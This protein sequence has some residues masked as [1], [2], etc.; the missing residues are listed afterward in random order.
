MN[1]QNGNYGGIPGSAPYYNMNLPSQ[2][3]SKPG[4]T[5]HYSER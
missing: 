2:N 5:E 4:G 1:N 3:G